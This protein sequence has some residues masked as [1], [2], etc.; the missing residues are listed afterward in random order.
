MAE[1]YIGIIYQMCVVAMDNLMIRKLQNIRE[2]IVSITP[3]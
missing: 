3:L 1:S 2:M